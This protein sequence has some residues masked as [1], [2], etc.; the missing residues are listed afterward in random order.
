LIAA[1]SLSACKTTIP[2]VFHGSRNINV[3]MIS[4]CGVIGYPKYPSHPQRIAASAITSFPVINF[5][6]AILE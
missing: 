2:V 6:S 5:I 4:D 3:S 1:T